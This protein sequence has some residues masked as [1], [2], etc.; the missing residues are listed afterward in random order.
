MWDEMSDGVARISSEVR[1]LAQRA[2]VVRRAIL[3]A[4]FAG[5]LANQDPADE[6]ASALLERL[7]ATRERPE[8]RGKVAS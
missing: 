6:A 7:R 5:D 4:A 3:R 1:A 2:G 8:R